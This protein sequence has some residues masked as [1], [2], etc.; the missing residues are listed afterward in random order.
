MSTGTITQGLSWRRAVVWLVGLVVALSTAAGCVAAGYLA[1]VASGPPKVVALYTPTTRP[2]AVLV[3]SRGQRGVDSALRDQ[4]ASLLSAELEENKVVPVVP[5]HR[6]YDLRHADPRTF[7]TLTVHDIGRKVGAEQVVYV[8]LVESDFVP[9]SAGMLL[10]GSL[11]AAVRVVD[12]PTGEV[13][14]PTNLSEG[15][16]VSV[17]TPFQERRAASP[18]LVREA[19]CRLMADRIARLFYTYRVDE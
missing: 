16:L 4:L 13:L 5:F 6:I 17:E 18:D 9:T 11:T 1:H 15:H 8:E 7:R 3:D 12:V 2:T 10:K 19:V 14:W